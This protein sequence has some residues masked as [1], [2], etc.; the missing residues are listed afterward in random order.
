MGI[1]EVVEISD[2]E[3]NKIIIEDFGERKVL[4]EIGRMPLTK[5]VLKRLLPLPE[6]IEIINKMAISSDYTGIYNKL[7][8]DRM[9]SNQAKWYLDN[10]LVLVCYF[11]LKKFEEAKRII[12]AQSYVTNSL[13]QVIM[14]I[15][16]KVEAKYIP[17]N[18][19]RRIK[20]YYS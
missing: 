11:R 6:D 15:A 9:I 13:P 14:A 8:K 7:Q 4:D 17:R 5:R 10:V 18:C 2:D 16:E 3:L 12:E 19:S 1:I 20:N